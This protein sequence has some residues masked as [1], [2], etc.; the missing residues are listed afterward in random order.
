MCSG[1]LDHRPMVGDQLQR[2]QGL[3]EK[4]S[5]VKKEN[6]KKTQREKGAKKGSMKEQSCLESAARRM[7]QEYAGTRERNMTGEFA[8]NCICT[9]SCMYNGQFR[10]RPG[11]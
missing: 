10:K 5:D 2:L 1:A 9:E 3:Q 8:N 7:E 11:E 4:I 6:W